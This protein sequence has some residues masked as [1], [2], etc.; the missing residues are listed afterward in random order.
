MNPQTALKQFGLNDKEIKVYLASLELGTASVLNIS[1]KARL[2]RPT[3]YIVLESLLE[4]GLVSEVPRKNK[5]LF[6]AENPEL[7]TKKLKEREQALAQSLPFLKS[8]YNISEKKPEVRFYEGRKGVETV[9]N[10]IMSSKE[11]I[12]WFGSIDYLNKY[13]PGQTENFIR[14]TKERGIKSREII[15][16]TKADHDYAKRVITDKNLVRILPKDLNFY[17]DCALFEN[18]VSLISLKK[19]FFAVIIESEPIYKSLKSLFELAW[20]AAKPVL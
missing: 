4:K 7:L 8:I 5:T 10:E 17:M 18:K 13:F 15:T 12:V 19:D 11:E 16:D 2:K 6:I 1:K 20:S 9:Y 3:T 14:I